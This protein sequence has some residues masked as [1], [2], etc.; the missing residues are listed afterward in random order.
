MEKKNIFQTQIIKVFK[1]RRISWCEVYIPIYDGSEPT[2]TKFF[3]QYMPF[4]YLSV[5][6]FTSNKTT[7][8]SFNKLPLFQQTQIYN[9]IMMGD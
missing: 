9:Y 8:S 7:Q 2:Y 1:Q 4:D 5:L 3:I 6:I